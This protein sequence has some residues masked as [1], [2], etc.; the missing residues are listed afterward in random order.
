MLFYIGDSTRTT[1]MIK[2]K[3]IE[4]IVPDLIQGPISKFV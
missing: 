1:T 4:E 3:I 2:E